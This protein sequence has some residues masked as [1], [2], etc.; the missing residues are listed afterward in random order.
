MTPHLTHELV[1]LLLLEQLGS[2]KDG[3]SGKNTEV[4][5]SKASSIITVVGAAVT[6]TATGAGSLA[7]I[8]ISQSI[9]VVE[10]A[11]V[12]ARDVTFQ[13]VEELAE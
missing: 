11:S 7:A 9:L 4:D 12:A 5:G 1:H 13:V 3:G 10:V 6:A 8:S 2:S